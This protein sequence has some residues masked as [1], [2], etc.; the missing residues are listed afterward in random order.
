M[1]GDRKYRQHGY[2]DSDR[3][4]FGNGTRRED[5]P[6]PQGPRPPIDVTGPR[7]PRM[8]QAVA[9]ARCYNCST[10]LPP[11]I[12]FR[13]TCPKCNA[14]LHCCKQCVYFE[15]ST[16]FQCLKPVPVRMSPKDAANQCELFKPK[17]TVARDA[18]QPAP[19]NGS[20]A[21]MPPVAEPRN[22]SDARAAFDSLFRKPE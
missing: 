22:A 12:D 10:A 3:D 19:S 7:L 21:T 20:G 18:A 9:A 11:D 6:R 8:V 17:V 1:D 4:H 15:P 13:G 2:Q 5:R 14:A 16:R